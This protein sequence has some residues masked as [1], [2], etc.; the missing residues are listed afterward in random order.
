M[1]GEPVHQGPFGDSRSSV[2]QPDRRHLLRLSGVRPVR[3]VTVA[4]AA[5]RTEVDCVVTVC[6]GRRITGF[7]ADAGRRTRTERAAQPAGRAG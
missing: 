1:D 6:N 2:S 7:D 4:R 3:A 5:P